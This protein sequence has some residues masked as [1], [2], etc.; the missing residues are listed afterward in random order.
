[1]P[2]CP[3]LFQSIPG[4]KSTFLKTGIRFNPGLKSKDS[5][6]KCTHTEKKCKNLS[7]HTPCSLAV[8]VF[9][10]FWCPLSLNLSHLHLFYLQFSNLKLLTKQSHLKVQLTKSYHGKKKKKKNRNPHFHGNLANFI[11]CGKAIELNA[12]KE[13]LTVCVGVDSNTNRFPIKRK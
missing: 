1:M 4:S 7:K 5:L 13:H 9:C 12:P 2:Q 11:C 8:T 3:G 6:F 10:H